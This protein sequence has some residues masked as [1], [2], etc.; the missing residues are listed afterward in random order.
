MKKFLLSGITIFAVAAPVWADSI[1][2]GQFNALSGVTVNTS[3]ASSSVTGSPYWNQGSDGTGNVG[4]FL[5]GTG[6]FTNQTQY[7][8]SGTGQYYSATGNTA[9]P[10]NNFSFLQSASTI[11]VTLLYTNAGQNGGTSGTQIGIYDVATGVKTALFGPGSGNG[12]LANAL[13]DCIGNVVNTACGSILAG[14][15]NLGNGTNGGNNPG[16]LGVSNVATYAQWGIYAITCT[17]T[18]VL[19]YSAPG[20]RTF[21]SGAAGGVFS[22]TNSG[23]VAP[24]TGELVNGLAHQ[25]FAVFNTTSAASTFYVGF[26]DWFGPNNNEGQLGDYNDVI[27]QFGTTDI[28]GIPEPGTLAL[29]G[30]GLAGLGVFRK[31][32]KQKQL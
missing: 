7:V 14:V 11:N 15:Y 27:L 26:E 18:A 28:A 13:G 24:G 2:G 32:R 8:T 23:T 9:N 29:L 16:T 25:H 17:D 19:N 12:S 10:S 1:T 3:G 31:I 22:G 30:L 20:C 6:N 4:A 21:Y 5:T